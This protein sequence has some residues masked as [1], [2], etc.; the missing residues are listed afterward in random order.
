MASEIIS[1]KTKPPAESGG[2]PPSPSPVI[3]HDSPLLRHT[4]SFEAVGWPYVANFMTT[5]PDLQAFPRFQ[6]LN[7]K[8]LLYYQVEISQ[9]SHKL[10]NQEMKDWKKR[11][12]NDAGKYAK[13]ADE[14]VYSQSTENHK[15]WD[16][17]L[18]MRGLLREYSKSNMH[19]IIK[20]AL[21]TK[22]IDTALL[23]F[24]QV[25]ALSEPDSYSIKNFV[26]WLTSPDAGNFC[27]GGMGSDVWGNLY[28]RPKE[29]QSRME[30]ILSIFRTWKDPKSNLDLVAIR[31][32]PKL[33]GF[34]RWVVN[35]FAPVFHR[36]K[37]SCCGIRRRQRVLDAEGGTTP[38]ERRDV[39]FK[40]ERKKK[41]I[42]L[43]NFWKPY[44]S[45]A[46]KIKANIS[47]RLRAN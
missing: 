23:Q 10:R 28:A 44:S 13:F 8:G 39:S 12:M 47:E 37:T 43:F 40:K 4:G 33:D 26:Q 3:I 41:R 35:D 9:L 27:I 16:L 32:P 7:V 25:S 29:P 1:E 46:F 21:T 15:Q 45:N 30:R 24:A 38:A 11:G 20:A 42:S 2:P 36:L 6:E 5:Q 31:P 22:H 14:L 18:K 19:S 17:I 34:T